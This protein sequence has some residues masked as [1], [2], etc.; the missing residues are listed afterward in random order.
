VQPA[1]PGSSAAALTCTWHVDHASFEGRWWDRGLDSSGIT[2]T[3]TRTGFVLSP[4]CPLPDEVSTFLPVPIPSRGRVDARNRRW[5]T[6]SSTAMV[7]SWYR[8]SA[9]TLWTFRPYFSYGSGSWSIAP[10]E[11]GNTFETRFLP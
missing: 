1:D 8:G 10:I 9:A 4:S 6:Y 3:V 5:R 7:R 11:T 2:S